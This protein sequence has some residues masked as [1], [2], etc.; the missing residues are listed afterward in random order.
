[1][2]N[3]MSEGKLTFFD[4]RCLYENEDI[5]VLFHLANFPDRTKEA[6]LAV[7]TLQ[8]DKTVRTGSGAT[9]TQ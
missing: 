2:F 1:M 6:I 5:L 7:H 9:P 8:D 3:A 4:Y